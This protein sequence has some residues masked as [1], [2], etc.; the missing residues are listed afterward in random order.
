MANKVG[1]PKKAE[2]EKIKYQLIAIRDSDY[3]ELKRKMG[4]NPQEKEKIAD[5][6]GNFIRVYEPGDFNEG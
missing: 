4:E 2:G 1:R 5:V 3:Q 6:I